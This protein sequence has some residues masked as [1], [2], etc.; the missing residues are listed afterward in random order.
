MLFADG[1]DAEQ[2]ARLAL[3]HRLAACAQVEG[4]ITSFYWWKGK[5]ERSEEWR[6]MF[7][8]TPDQLSLL[9][10]RIL[11]SH[12]YEIPEWI[13]LYGGI[14][15]DRVTDDRS[16]TQ[17]ISVRSAEICCAPSAKANLDD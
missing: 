8:A 17:D 15:Q 2:L 13:G 9:E 14:V 3:E 5:L 10:S 16:E 11:A 7:K 1:S 6:I 4:P 12:P